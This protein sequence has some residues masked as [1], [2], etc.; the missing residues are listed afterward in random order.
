MLEEVLQQWNTPQK[1]DIVTFPSYDAWQQ[2][3][4]AES[5]VIWDV[6]PSDEENIIYECSLRIPVIALHSS[7]LLHIL[8]NNIP[9]ND[10]PLY[11][12][13]KPLS[14]LLFIA[15]LETV[16]TNSQQDAVIKIGNFILSPQRKLLSYI[17]GAENISV[18]LTEK[19]QDII[20]YLNTHNEVAVD[21]NI[22]LDEI[23]GYDESVDTHTV[24]THIYRLRQK[25]AAACH[26]NTLIT[27]EMSGYNLSGE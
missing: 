5:C 25:I 22:L 7:T 10:T 15:Q 26:G 20:L 1:A 24:E 8:S 13:T 4:G 21:K 2:T 12:L 19:E 23:W 14:L 9:S 17:K 18:P 6:V 27:T 3:S 16:L 11:K